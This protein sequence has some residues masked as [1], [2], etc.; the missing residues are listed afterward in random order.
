MSGIATRK[1]A[2]GAI[3]QGS[4]IPLPSN[5]TADNFVQFKRGMSAVAKSVPSAIGGEYGHIYLL[6]DRTA[7]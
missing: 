2:Y 6:E 4:V 5:F 1:A 3:K 7:Y